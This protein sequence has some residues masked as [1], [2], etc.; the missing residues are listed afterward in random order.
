MT[1]S[2]WHGTWEIRYQ[3]ICNYVGSLIWIKTG[4]V[5]GLGVVVYNL[6]GLFVMPCQNKY[7]FR[8]LIGKIIF[9]T[10]CNTYRQKMNAISDLLLDIPEQESEFIVR[11]LLC[12]V[13]YNSFRLGNNLE[14]LH[15][16]SVCGIWFKTENTAKVVTK[17]VA[18]LMNLLFVF[19]VRLVL[20]QLIN[21]CSFTPISILYLHK[22]K[23]RYKCSY[24]KFA[25]D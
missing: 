14:F 7:Y 8:Y 24:N 9:I 3:S 10:P 18:T 16:A 19:I 17:N 22:P 11:F 5:K 13:E 23:S 4:L 20:K 15:V 21:W 1:H 2:L 25:S 12:E 6:D